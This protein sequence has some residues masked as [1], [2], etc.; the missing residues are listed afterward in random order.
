MKSIVRPIAA[1]LLLLICLFGSVFAQQKRQAPARPQPKVA[2][3]PAPTF[4]TLLPADAYNFYGEVRSVGGF[5]RSSAVT[6]LLDPIIKLSGPPKEFTTMVK[7][8]NSHADEM[9]TSRL[10]VASW[11]AAKNVP[12]LLVAI[13][14]ETPEEAAK[15]AKPLNDY[16]VKVFP[17]TVPAAEE[18]TI[19]LDKGAVGEKAKAAPPKPTGPPKPSFYIKQTGSL[20][21]L[22]P[23]PLDLKKFRP[24]GSKLL[25]EDNNF[26]AARNRFTSEPL[27]AFFNMKSIE[28][29]EEEQRKKYDK[30]RAEEQKKM[31]EAALKEPKV[32]IE[33]EPEENFTLTEE[34]VNLTPGIT[35]ATVEEAKGS[36][37]LDPAS[38]VINLFA[39]SLFGSSESKWPEGIALALSLENESFDLRALFLNQS[40]EKSDAV[41]FLP[42]LIPGQSIIPESP[43]VLP[44]DSEML[45]TMSL[46]WQQVYSYLARPGPI[47]V[48]ATRIDAHTIE[49]GNPSP[50]EGLE[51]Q[52]Q[53]NFKNDVLPLLG[54]EVALRLP[55]KDVSIFGL[56]RP[57]GTPA[58]ETKSSP[59][60]APVLLLS[61]KD[62]EGV[63]ALMPKIIE[64]LGFKGASMLAQTERQ[65]DTE[66]VSYAGMFSYAFV[67]NFL[68]LSG[69]PA[70]IKH[71]VDSYL[72][73]ETLAGDSQF[74][75][76]TRWQPRPMHGQLF[77]S[78][79]LM[80]SY[81]SWLQQPST[82][83]TDDVKALLM[84]LTEMGQPITYS[85][86]N[87]GL[88]PLHEVHLPKN[89]VLMA[90]TGASGQANPPQD[91]MNERRASAALY[92]IAYA[93]RTYKDGK[94]F[95][96]Y[97]TIEQLVAEELLQKDALEGFGYKF[98]LTLTGDKFE[99]SATPVEYGK[100]G[101]LSYFLDETFVLRGGD[102]NGAAANSSD[103]PISQ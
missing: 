80:E 74:K 86:S 81:K 92:S 67:G 44:A 21:L 22:T 90:V 99:V 84:R 25:G 103:P 56:L 95:A 14:F 10:M 71:V 89:L 16:L 13:E 42:V 62:K 98:D 47:P 41:P 52:L 69:D 9:M 1:S 83:M 58:G 79:A 48:T 78:S 23:T 19:L 18:E 72:K 17:P 4:E 91:L 7:W 94:G 87:E 8:L 29:E 43:N 53:L 5:I 40:G 12:E 96:T 75:N 68:V 28:R 20:I 49:I 93:Q 31:E 35:A 100:S 24:A 39:S 51:Q 54:S 65:D 26:R 46:D 2:P 3:T 33:A 27:F 32:E 38:A 101:K 45:V 6:E 15:F 64:K 82:R 61:L 37:P 77:I 88:G 57:G 63:R 70:T 60:A 66:I 34:T 76:F 55:V 59:N 11:P 73:R 102:K 30:L 97:G 36:P 85:L 50:L